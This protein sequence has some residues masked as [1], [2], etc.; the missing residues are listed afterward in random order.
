MHIE[1]EISEKDFRD[2]QR[3][4]IKGSKSL[5]IHW[6][7][8]LPP[9]IGLVTLIYIIKVAASQGFSVR[10]VP[11]I[12]I[13]VLFVLMPILTRQTQNKLYTKS[14][15]L[16]GRISLDVD[17]AGLRFLGQTS[18][19]NASWNHYSRFLENDKVFVLWQK[20]ERLFNI[21]P[22]L[23]LTPEQTASLRQILQ[24]HLADR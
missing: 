19:S 22:K 16:R 14:S 9:S 21:V 24:H 8:F 1:Y 20:D 10:V 12:V 5:A 15:S 7:T 6:A 18:S 2:G 23:V 3:L 4:A 17:D 11:G 13:S